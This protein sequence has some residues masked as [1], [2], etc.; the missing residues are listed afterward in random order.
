MLVEC[1]GVDLVLW[2]F[3]TGFEVDCLFDLGFECYEFLI[4]ALCLRMCW[5]DL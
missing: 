3:V 1:L 4:D 2:C 5:D